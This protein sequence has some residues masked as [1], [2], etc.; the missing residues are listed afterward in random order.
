MGENRICA[1]LISILEPVLVVPT[2]LTS[3]LLVL[4]D[5]YELF[6]FLK[7]EIQIPQMSGPCGAK[8]L[9]A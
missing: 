9:K 4:F 8:A 3:R 1:N 6:G 2:V 5:L 7:P